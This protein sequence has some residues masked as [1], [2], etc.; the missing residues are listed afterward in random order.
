MKSLIGDNVLDELAQT[1]AKTPFGSIVE[2]GVYQGGSALRLYQVAREQSRFLYLYDT[3]EGIPFKD[4]VDAH[5]VGDFKDCSF[6]AIQ[7]AFAGAVVTK[8]IFPAS[9][10]SMPPVAFAHLDCNQ[11]KSVYESIWYLA[12]RMVDGGILWLNDYGA[13]AGATKAVEDLI[14]KHL[15]RQ[16]GCG[17]TYAVTDH[18]FYLL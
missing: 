4:A 10:V 18:N 17:K 3:F 6:H 7:S 15:L 8:G 1:A 11:Y 5:A 2:V 13:L 14:P 12:P 16:A 9:A